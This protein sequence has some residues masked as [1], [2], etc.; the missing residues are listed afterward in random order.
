MIHSI[1]ISSYIKDLFNRR[2]VGKVHSQFAS[3][4]NLL[5]EEKLVNVNANPDFI[6]SFGMTLP[7]ECVRDVIEHTEVGD[8]VVVHSNGI[9]FYGRTKEIN[10]EVTHLEIIDLEIDPISAAELVVSNGLDRLAN[11]DYHNKIG[12]QLT[13]K[14][15]KVIQFLE[16][17]SLNDLTANEEAMLHLIGRG[18]G[19]TPSGDDFLMGFTMILIAVDKDKLWRRQLQSLVDG[20]TTDISLAYYRSLFE[21]SVSSSYKSLL[22]GIKESDLLIC[23]RSIEQIKKFGHTSGYDSLYGILTGAIRIKNLLE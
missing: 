12:L 20:K 1:R 11:I 5:I 7:L 3:S 16:T 23:H 10:V 9:R 6:S 18:K 14:T 15:Q 2:H 17:S 22:K 13:P 4:F 19:L 21:L 8:I